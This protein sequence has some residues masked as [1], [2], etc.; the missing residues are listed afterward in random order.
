MSLQNLILRKDAYA[1]NKTS[2]QSLERHV[3]KFAKA[4]QL[5]LT[6]GA[7]QHN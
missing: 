3:L 4:A 2:K 1:L 6:K 7:L 5:L